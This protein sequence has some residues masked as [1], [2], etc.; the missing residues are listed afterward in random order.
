MTD[1]HFIIGLDRRRQ[2]DLACVVGQRASV[3]RPFHRRMDGKSV[4]ARLAPDFVAIGECFEYARR[5]MWDVAGRQ[6]PARLACS[7]RA[8]TRASWDFAVLMKPRDG[9]GLPARL[10]WRRGASPRPAGRGLP[11]E[12]WRGMA[13]HAFE[14]TLTGCS[15]FIENDSGADVVERASLASRWSAREDA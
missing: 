15:D 6:S 14:V 3:R 10:L 12:T 8:H 7:T 13:L 5:Q 11:P 1:I 4:R 9:Q 2:D